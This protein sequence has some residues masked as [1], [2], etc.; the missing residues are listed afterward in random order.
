MESERALVACEVSEVIEAV[1]PASF[2]KVALQT[3][4]LALKLVD[5]REMVR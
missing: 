5:T 2:H 3:K 1:E 4:E